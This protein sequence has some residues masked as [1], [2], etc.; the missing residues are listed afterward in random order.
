MA[1][2]GQVESALEA[3]FGDAPI[4]EKPAPVA[5]PEAVV[6]EEE[7]PQELAAEEPLEGPDEAVEPEESAPVSEP[8]YEIV[9]DGE[10]HVVRGSD[11]VKELISKGLAYNK[12]HGALAKMQEA[13][14]AREEGLRQQEQF[15]GQIAGD[16]AELRALDSRLEEYNKIDWNAAF[17]SDP[18][19][20]LKLKEQR[21]QLR[22]ARQGKIGAL[23][24]KH[25][26][27]RQGQ[28]QAAQRMLA[29][30]HAALLEKVPEWRNSEKAAAEKQDITRALTERYGFNPA[31]LAAINDH[32]V[33]V[34]MREHVRMLKAQESA[35]SKQVRTAP[36]VVKPGSVQKSNPKAE[37]TK[38][39]EHVRKL[40]KQGN[41]KAQEA[42][43][44]EL[45]SRTFKI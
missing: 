38:V 21:D 19:N 45:L 32:R 23:N 35:K 44:T 22:E 42:A 39:R 33:L 20:A 11:Q 26:Q 36:P 14:V 13:F 4:V 25:E 8:E 24:Q 18:F 6:P 40:G 2:E 29:A 15:T 27:F 10:T 7:A 37:F 9:A 30:E 1:G 43:V 31:E 17:E 3:A 16:L 12:R 34:I 28:A 41:H 5:E